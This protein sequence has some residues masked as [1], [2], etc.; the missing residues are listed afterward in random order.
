MQGKEREEWETM[1]DW[2]DYRDCG[3]QGIW[4]E[5]ERRVLFLIDS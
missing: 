3:E 4:R 1:V 5:G 2:R